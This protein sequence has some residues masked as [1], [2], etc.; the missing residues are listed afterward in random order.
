MPKIKVSA[1]AP[2]PRV[3]KTFTVTTNSGEKFELTVRRLLPSQYL[4]VTGYAEDLCSVLAANPIQVTTLVDGE[5]VKDDLHI[6]MSAARLI[7]T[8]QM[9]QHTDGA[10]AY[11]D[12]EIARMMVDEMVTTQLMSIYEWV[13]SAPVE[14][15]PGNS[16]PTRSEASSGSSTESDSA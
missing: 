14:D 11:Q 2:R 16:R 8:L 3:S 10:D 7:V 13:L 5:E 1:L 12:E 15:D 6:S 4:S 9:A